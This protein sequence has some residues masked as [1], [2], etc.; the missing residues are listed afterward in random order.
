VPVSPEDG[1]ASVRGIHFLVHNL[2]FG[3][4]S[5]LVV[6]LI[7]RLLLELLVVSLLEELELLGFI[8]VALSLQEVRYRVVVV[9]HEGEPLRVFV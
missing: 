3:R 8:I 1:H 2:L 9:P 7:F 6:L 4:S 5:F